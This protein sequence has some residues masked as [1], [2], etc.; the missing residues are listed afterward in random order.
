MTDEPNPPIPERPMLHGERVWLRPLEGRDMPAYV[1]GINDMDVGGM[2]GYKLPLSVEQANHW[3]EETREQSRSG[4]GYYFAICELGDDGFIGTVWLRDISLIDGSGQLAIFVDHE[5]LG[6]GYGADAER[7]L[8][9]FAFTNLGLQRVWLVAYA[10]NR[11]AIHSYEK[12]G[13][14][15][16]GLMRKSWRGPRG[17]EDA[18]LMAILRDE[19]L[20]EPEMPVP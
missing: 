7:A 19:W 8:L 20:G 12:L 5:H 2:A 1:A 15:H 4:R 17:L 18:V 6:S 14:R 10:A 9:N 16:E 13:F 3:L 11:R